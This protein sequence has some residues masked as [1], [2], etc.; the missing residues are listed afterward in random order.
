MSKPDFIA[1]FRKILNP[2]HSL[3]SVPIIAGL[4]ISF[5]AIPIVIFIIFDNSK[6]HTTESPKKTTQ[7]QSVKAQET[8]VIGLTKKILDLNSQLSEEPAKQKSIEKQMLSTAVERE[9]IL[10]QLI[11]LDPLSVSQIALSP[12]LRSSLPKKIQNHIE[13]PATLEGPLEVL[14]SDDFEKNISD[15]EYLLTIKEGGRRVSLHFV[16]QEDTNLLSGSK[17]RV[18][19]LRLKDKMVVPTTKEKD[20]KIISKKSN[21]LPTSNIKKVA[22]ILFNFQNDTSQPFT[23]DY[24]RK[25]TFT[26]S[27]SVNAYFKEISHGNKSLTGIKRADGDIYGWYTLPYNNNVCD[28]LTWAAAAEDLVGQEYSKYYY[29]DYFIFA[30][31][32]TS[33]CPYSG[34]ALGVPGNT[35]L[36]NGRYTTRVVAHELGHNF[37][38]LHASTLNCTNESG[39]RVAISNKCKSNEYG[40]PFDIMGSRVRHMN[41]QHKARLGWYETGNIKKIA[42]SG[43]YTLSPIETQG[44]GTKALIIE[45]TILNP[46]SLYYLEYRKTFGFDNFKSTDPVVNGV[47]I[48]VAGDHTN[49]LLNTFLIDNTPE[50][51]TFF[52]A[53]LLVDK[54]FEDKS[55]GLKIEVLGKEGEN[56][57]V[58][59]TFEQKPDPCVR[60]NPSASISPLSQWATMGQAVNYFVSITNNDDE[61]CTSSTFEIK[62]T[63]PKNIRNANLSIPGITLK[64]GET[65]TQRISIT[66]DLLPTYEKIYQTF[67]AEMRNSLLPNYSAKISANYNIYT[68]E[69]PP[70][71][72]PDGTDKDSDGDG[73]TDSVEIY[74]GTDPLDKCADDSTDAAWPPDFD[75]NKKINIE[76]VL[77]I[78][79]VFDS[80]KGDGVYNNRFDLNVDAIIDTNDV[81][82]L[83]PIFNST[84]SN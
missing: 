62:L 26:G 63:L 55:E 31:P 64:P 17:V 69:K 61:N 79:P 59:V 25:T 36:I 67:T 73:F 10:L 66:S 46:N 14:H 81:L 72:P 38:V 78:K 4:L 33:A 3:N 16:Q 34:V 84:C 19:G 39:Q 1:K 5:L 50:T 7:I 24:I 60:E 53:A 71:P 12:K 54:T 40:D 30:F 18:T 65:R 35:S 22:V 11:E 43:T 75:N 52:D 45:N 23:E 41:T 76:D 56:L 51:L 57:R 2:P 6:E 37:G 44:T 49:K 74:L 42:E 58:K 27:S 20:F 83:K 77:S 13:R 32:R 48:R 8:R 15:L 82:L 28:E 9:D 68:P 70:P 80:K 47:S 21:V 29:Y